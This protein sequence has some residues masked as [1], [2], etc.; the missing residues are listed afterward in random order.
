LKSKDLNIRNSVYALRAVD[1]TTAPEVNFRNKRPLPIEGFSTVPFHRGYDITPD[2]NEFVMTFP[3]D[4]T[5][6]L[7]SEN[8]IIN[9][10]QNW[11][12]ELKRLVPVD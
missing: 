10:I 4:P 6:S 8:H 5:E 7:E 3:V 12:E 9:I 2:G 1:I 11:D